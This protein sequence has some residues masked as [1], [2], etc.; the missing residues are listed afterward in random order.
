MWRG[1]RKYEPLKL[2]KWFP[3]CLGLGAK[4]DLLQHT[5]TELGP[6]HWQVLI[7]EKLL[8]QHVFTNWRTVWDSHWLIV[9][10]QTMIKRL[11]LLASSSP[12]IIWWTKNTLPRH[13]Y[14]PLFLYVTHSDTFTHLLSPA[15]AWSQSEYEQTQLTSTGHDDLSQ[16][17]SESE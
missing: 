7:C 13:I 8:G 2:F 5:Q 15:P 9:G 17:E 6:K 16:P 4:L 3:H 1:E 14:E 10:D 12:V 11:F